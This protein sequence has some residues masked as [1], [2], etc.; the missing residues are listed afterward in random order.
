LAEKVTRYLSSVKSSDNSTNQ[1]SEAQS[2]PLPNVV[3]VIAK[4]GDPVIRQ[5]IPSIVDVP[6]T[7][8][9]ENEGKFTLDVPLTSQSFKSLR[10]IAF[11][12]GLIIPKNP[13]KTKLIA[14]IEDDMTKPDADKAN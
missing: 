11:M 12:R 4:D 2:K 13:S 5:E 3:K 9:I 8:V 7:E 14:L 10:K 1:E 6:S